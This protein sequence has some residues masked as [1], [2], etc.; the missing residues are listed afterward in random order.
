[1]H[2]NMDVTFVDDAALHVFDREPFRAI[3]AMGL[4]ILTAQ[5][6][7]WFAQLDDR[8]V[9]NG[10]RVLLTG[11]PGNLSLG[12]LGQNHLE[13]LVARGNWLQAARE[14]FAMRRV[15]GRPV[16][17]TV[18]TSI[19]GP[20]WPAA[21]RRVRRRWQRVGEG[22][23]HNTFLSPAFAKE[24]RLAERVRDIGGWSDEVMVGDTFDARAYWLINARTQGH[25]L[26]GQTLATRGIEVR[27][28]LADARLV[29]F[30][31]NVPEEHYLRDGRPRALQRD[32]I[33]DRVPPEIYDNYK[34]GEQV[35][36]WFDRLS[37]RRDGLL[38]DIERIARSPLA[39]RAIDVDGLR[40]AAQNW[41]ADA[42][43]AKAAGPKFRY[44]VARAVAM[45]NF[46]RWF[47]GGN[48]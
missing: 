10:H 21:L 8:V 42:R 6:F 15:T 41:P 30:C 34:F 3:A 18:R 38:A 16:M 48:R 9:A 46:I 43:A 12:W 2:P 13:Q 44:G 19:L 11:Q 40:R 20:R 4:P 1:M 24:H 32:V 17:A 45:G 22:H 36:E 7:G 35:P 28:P 5:N 31:L 29:E 26:R 37:A 25:D 27:E 39:S 14:V 47:E 33:A 23:E